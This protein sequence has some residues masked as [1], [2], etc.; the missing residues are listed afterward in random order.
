MRR[1]LLEIAYDGTNYCGWQVQPDLP[2]VENEINKG[3]SA[4]LNEQIEVIGASRTDSGVHALGNIA[5]FDTNSRIP[6]DKFTLALNQRL[7]EDIR[8]QTSKEVPLDFHP[9]RVNCRKT[10]RYR[11]LN[12]RIALPTD[13]YYSH[14]VYYPLSLELMKKAGSYL[15]GDHDYKSFCS[16]KTQVIDTVRTIYDLRVAR[17]DKNGDMITITIEGN[18]FLY[19]MIRII[20]GT[21]IEVGRGALLPEDMP[22]ILKGLDRSLAGPTA[23]PEGLILMK[24]DYGNK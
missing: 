15:I 23:P 1:I 16:V 4:L 22:N 8:V 2:T 11:I 13:R 12:R 17:E 5:V 20:A 10:Y 18:G 7:P 6:A 24:I 14:F 21:L 9:R 3:L 19:N